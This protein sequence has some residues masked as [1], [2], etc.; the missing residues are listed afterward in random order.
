MMFEAD[1]TIDAADGSVA[2]RIPRLRLSFEK[3]YWNGVLLVFSLELFGLAMHIA[4]AAPAA[5]LRRKLRYFL[6]RAPGM[7]VTAMFIA[8]ISCV[9]ADLALRF[10]VSP[11]AHRWRSPGGMDPSLLAF[12]LEIGERVFAQAPGRRRLG[13]RRWQRGNVVVTNRRLLFLPSAWETEPFT[14]PIAQIR[15]LA[16]QNAPPLLGGMI[17]G[18]PRRFVA[19]DSNNRETAFM[20]AN[21]GQFLEL[22]AKAGLPAGA[23][24]E[25]T[26]FN[27]APNDPLRA[28]S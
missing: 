1:P 6:H 10:V 18:A 7:T 16:L 15:G 14:I 24:R 28:I 26:L 13:R 12:H 8:A 19:I 2:R 5:P 9:L 22:S 11:L 3:A 25:A 4:T 27:P 20:L 23:R 21:A 17:V